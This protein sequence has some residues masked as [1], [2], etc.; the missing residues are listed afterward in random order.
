M[1][2]ASQTLRERRVVS[3]PVIPIAKCVRNVRLGFT[4]TEDGLARED[5][6]KLNVGE[7]RLRERE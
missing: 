3:L 1:N 7:G 6:R 4:L 5:V 2:I